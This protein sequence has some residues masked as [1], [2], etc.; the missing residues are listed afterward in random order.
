[1]K[2]LKLTTWIVIGMVPGIAVGYACHA[3]ISDAQELKA[4]VTAREAE[5]V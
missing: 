4:L 1:M 3:N 2:R 5:K